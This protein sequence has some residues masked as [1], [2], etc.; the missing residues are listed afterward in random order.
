MAS[1]SLSAEQVSLNSSPAVG[2]EDDKSILTFV[3]IRPGV[4]MKNL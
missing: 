1:P 2:D 4:I 3:M